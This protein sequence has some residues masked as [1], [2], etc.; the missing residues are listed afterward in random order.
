M[1]YVEGILS[2]SGESGGILLVYT[3][4][5][6]HL[7]IQQTSSTPPLPVSVES[8]GTIETWSLPSGGSQS[9]GRDR[10]TQSFRTPW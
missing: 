1:I 7:V 8:T 3:N 6:I 2:L 10:D 9:R 4:S 5:F